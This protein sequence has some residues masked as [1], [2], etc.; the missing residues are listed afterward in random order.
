MTRSPKSIF[1]ILPPLGKK[2]KIWVRKAGI[3]GRIFSA[4]LG[5]HRACAGQ[6]WEGGSSACFA[7][8]AQIALIGMYGV[9]VVVCWQGNWRQCW[10]IGSGSSTCFARLMS[11]VAQGKVEE[12]GSGAFFACIARLALGGNGGVLGAMEFSQCWHW[13]AGV[14]RGG[15][16]QSI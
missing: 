4:L 7:R 3:H 10:V 6:S 14:R 9:L 1:Y 12:G 16:Q 8:V 13:H 15:N 11:W 5:S 2:R